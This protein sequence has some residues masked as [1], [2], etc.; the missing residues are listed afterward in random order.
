MKNLRKVCSE[1]KSLKGFYDGGYLQLNYN[2]TDDNVFTN[3]HYGLG[4]TWETNYDDV[5]II[6][7]GIICTPKTQKEILKMVENALTNSF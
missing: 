6:N 7:C 5:N 3:Y 2:K 1:T 4:H